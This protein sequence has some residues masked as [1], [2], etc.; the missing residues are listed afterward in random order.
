MIVITGVLLMVLAANLTAIRRTSFSRWLYLP[1][2]LSL[3]MLYFVPRDSILAL[4]LVARLMWSLLVVPLPIFFAG[5]IF[6][7]TFRDGGNPAQLLGANLIGAMVGGFAE[8]LA[9][10]TGQQALMLIVV[11]AYLASFAC[12]RLPR[13]IA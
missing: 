6:S 1:L 11:G 12:V 9:M 10:V 5:L 4:P 8:Y 3:L 7:L 2:L 13:R